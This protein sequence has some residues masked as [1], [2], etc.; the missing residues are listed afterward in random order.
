MN[1]PY[2]YVNR[3]LLNFLIGQKNYDEIKYKI[4]IL[5]D[6]DRVFLVK[7]PIIAIRK[8]LYQK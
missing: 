1:N 4:N 2:S 8:H 5:N 7:G 6:P 3:K